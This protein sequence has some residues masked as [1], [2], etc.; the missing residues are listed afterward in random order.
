MGCFRVAGRETKYAERVLSLAVGGLL[1]ST[2]GCAAEESG[3]VVPA[4]ATTPSEFRSP[5]VWVGV[6][7]GPIAPEPVATP[8][9]LLGP[10]VHISEG[11][12]LGYE[13]TAEGQGR[14]RFRWTTDNRVHHTGV[15]RFHGTVFTPGHFVSLVP[16]CD[17]QSCELE[18]GDF[19]SAIEPVPT[20]GERIEWDTLAKDGW[21]GFSFAVDGAPLYF[22]IYVDGRA[23]PE[24]LDVVRWERPSPPL[25]RVSPGS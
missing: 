18:D 6:A 5:G 19:V 13:L 8:V 2:V 12:A 14:Y 20:G 15:R 17:D 25:V 3:W 11:R 21:D 4:S 9:P 1:L 16:G 7:G 24:L 23:R 22:E 10:R